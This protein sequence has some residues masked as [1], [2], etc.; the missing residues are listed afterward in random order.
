MFLLTLK[1][2]TMKTNNKSVFSSENTSATGVGESKNYIKDSDVAAIL[3]ESSCSTPLQVYLRKKGRMK[4]SESGTV[5]KFETVFG[6]EMADY[7]S[8]IMGLRTRRI[9]QPF[10]HSEHPYLR[11]QIHHEILDGESEYG[12]G[13]LELKTTTSHWLSSFNGKYPVEWFY[14][15][16]YHLGLTNYSYAYLFIYE[17]D[18]CKYYEPILI[19]RDEKWVNDIR[20]KL[21]RWWQRHIVAGKEPVPIN[22]KDAF[23]LYPDAS[24]RI[25]EASAQDRVFHE[26]L[27]N[28]NKKI[29]SL[30][31]EKELLE[32][33]LKNSMGEGERL[34]SGGKDLITWKNQTTRSVNWRELNKRFPELCRKFQ[35]FIKTRRFVVK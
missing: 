34:V 21:I 10:I 9:S 18:T 15:I 2:T 16:Q 27:V 20:Q 5:D 23:L 11:A 29:S 25:V 8:R 4:P 32:A 7:F 13:I 6:S 33:Y 17:R 14:Q 19:K 22:G 28:I 30:E 35:K 26:E 3:K 31:I 24:E 12:S 1:E